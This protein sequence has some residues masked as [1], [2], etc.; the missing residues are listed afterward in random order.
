MQTRNAEGPRWESRHTNTRTQAHANSALLT[1]NTAVAIPSARK[2]A[3]L[4]V[5]VRFSPADCVLVL[6]RPCSPSPRVQQTGLFLLLFFLLHSRQMST[7]SKKKNLKKIF[8]LLSWCRTELDQGACVCLGGKSVFKLRAITPL[9][10]KMRE[11]KNSK[12][13]GRLFVK[14]QNIPR[15]KGAQC[16]TR[17]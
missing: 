16:S 11:K 8:A 12:K 7:S 17:C 3:S 15:L 10:K 14:P 6:H 9:K 4:S 13:G 2:S 5:T 1:W